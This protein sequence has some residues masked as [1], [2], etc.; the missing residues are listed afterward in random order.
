MKKYLI[1]L[2]FLS[3]AA[4]INANEINISNKLFSGSIDNYIKAFKDCKRKSNEN[5]FQGEYE[6]LKEFEARK[7]VS[8]SNC[9][10]FKKAKITTPWKLNYK[11]NEEYF[12]LDIPEA[13]NIRLNTESLYKIST[14]RKFARKWNSNKKPSNFWC[15]KRRDSWNCEGRQQLYIASPKVKLYNKGIKNINFDIEGDQLYS[16]YMKG[17]G[18][19]ES[20]HPSKREIEEK[21]IKIL[22]PVQEARALK[23]REQDLFLRFTGS[24]ELDDKH[25]LKMN[26]ERL[27]VYDGSV[28]N[29]LASLKRAS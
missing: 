7:E 3:L 11:V 17:S 9:S 14:P 28:D 1:T 23:G 27:D 24:I 13:S 20:F 5:L 8:R 10:E 4:N 29:K 22:V 19:D 15:R 6:T 25:G 26:I 21:P 16:A 12:V 2:F 18:G